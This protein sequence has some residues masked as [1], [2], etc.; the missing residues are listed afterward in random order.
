MPE[1]ELMNIKYTMLTLPYPPSVGNGLPHE[2]LIGCADVSS[3]PSNRER[4]LMNVKHLTFAII[5]VL[6]FQNLTETDARKISRDGNTPRGEDDF[7]RRFHFDLILYAFFS[8][9]GVLF[10]PP[11]VFKYPHFDKNKT[12]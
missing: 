2:Y 3:Q 6:H 4:S 1:A 8:Y 5:G 10:A 12:N 7:T 9:N 11:L